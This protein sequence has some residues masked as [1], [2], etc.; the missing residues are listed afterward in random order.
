MRTAIREM[1][2]ELLEIKPRNSLITKI[3]H[4][5]LP[6]RILLNK[7]YVLVEYCFYQLEQILQMASLVE[8]GSKLYMRFPETVGDLILHRIHRNDAEVPILYLLPL[9]G[10]SLDPG[11]K[12]D[13]ELI[14]KDAV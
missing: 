9:A 4:T 8:S 2:E 12:K 1:L 5:F 13:I 14:R 7:S 10:V 11:F 6:R 3:Q